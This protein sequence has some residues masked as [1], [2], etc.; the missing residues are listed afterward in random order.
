MSDK[1]FNAFKKYVY[2]ICATDSASCSLRE[3]RMVALPSL[4]P[5]DY[6]YLSTLY[7][8]NSSGFFKKVILEMLK[9]R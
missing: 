5:C 1:L 8:Q 7:F 4:Q 2:I 3:R 6:S 9:I